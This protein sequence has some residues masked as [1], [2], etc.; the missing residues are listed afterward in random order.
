M[1]LKSG[2]SSSER[3]LDPLSYLPIRSFEAPSYSVQEL[4]LLLLSLIF[5]FCSLFP[6]SLL[7]FIHTSPRPSLF[8]FALFVF[9]TVGACGVGGDVAICT[10]NATV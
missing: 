9:L 1:Q 6:L 5:F 2:F 3:F 10:P 8:F 4:M 7:V